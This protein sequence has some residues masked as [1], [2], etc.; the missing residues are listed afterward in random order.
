MALKLVDMV[1]MTGTVSLD[2]DAT[3][4]AAV[5]GFRTLAAAGVAEGDTFPYRLAAADGSLWETG[6]GLRYDLAGVTYMTR[7]AHE[8]VIFDT[9]TPC[10]LYV[11]APSWMMPAYDVGGAGSAEKAPS[12]ANATAALALGGGSIAQASGAVAVGALASAAGVRSAAVG[13]NAVAATAGSVALGSH[14]AVSG[15]AALGRGSK[16]NAA[17]YSGVLI[18]T[19]W[20]D[21]GAA[22]DAEGSRFGLPNVPCIALLDV[23]IS[24]VKD[25]FTDTYAARASVVVKRTATNGTI[26]IEGTPVVTVIKDDA[27]AA[28]PAFSVFGTGASSALNIDVGVSMAANA[29]VIASVSQV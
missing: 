17:D 28:A 5:E 11:A 22:L 29:V 6:V 7:Y 1:A 12:Q 13:Y 23:L 4:A 2:E 8:P 19:G 26:S 18:W 14:T 9:D 15:C 20:R 21:S 10:V 24:G 25:G 3:L 16:Q 27:G